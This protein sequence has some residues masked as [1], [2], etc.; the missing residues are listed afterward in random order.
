VDSSIVLDFALQSLEW[1]FGVL[2]IV[3]VGDLIVCAKP[4]SCFKGG[5]AGVTGEVVGDFVVEL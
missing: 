4:V 3:I 2:A 1:S 5:F